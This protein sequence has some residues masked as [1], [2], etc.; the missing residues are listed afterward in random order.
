MVLAVNPPF[1]LFLFLSRGPG[2]VKKNSGLAV[3]GVEAKG[4]GGA[5]GAA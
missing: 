3:G 2:R 5:G 1:C 4:A